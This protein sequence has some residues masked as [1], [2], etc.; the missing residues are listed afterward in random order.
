LTNL[1]IPEFHG[2]IFLHVEKRFSDALEL[3]S[4]TPSGGQ[5]HDILLQPA[6]DIRKH[7]DLVVTPTAFLS[8]KFSV[9]SQI[10]VGIWCSNF[11]E[12]SKLCSIKVS[13]TI[14]FS[15][16][17]FSILEAQ[18]HNRR[19]IILAKD[20]K[21]GSEITQSHLTESST[22]NIDGVS[23]SKAHLLIGLR[24]AYDLNAGQTLDFGYVK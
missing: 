17:A 19:V 9:A 24:V 16:N 11:N 10:S 1:A 12:L 3:F 21:R 7:F 20:I 5:W 2:G 22:T 23:M 14:I 15:P 4:T 8:S 6:I 13:A 18:R